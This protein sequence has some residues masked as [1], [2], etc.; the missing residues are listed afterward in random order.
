[1]VSESETVSS[2]EAQPFSMLPP[3][4]VLQ[5]LR[6][7][8]VFAAE[9]VDDF[10]EDVLKVALLLFVWFG[11]AQLLRERSRTMVCGVQFGAV[12][13]SYPAADRMAESLD[14]ILVPLQSKLHTWLTGQDRS[15][16]REKKHKHP[17]NAAAALCDELTED[18][19]KLACVACHAWLGS[20][21]NSALLT[22]AAPRSR[23][24]RVLAQAAGGVMALGAP[25][26]H[27]HECD[28][29]GDAVGHAISS[30]FFSVPND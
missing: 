4:P 1:M 5:E 29:Y 8:M 21:L 10:V 9:S 22:S 11:V 13:L 17:A 7:L 26:A 18:A 16:P 25:A 2:M 12:L 14:D 30:W 28:Q 19:V 3:L 20:V 15:L 6:A 27:Y 24:G 23:V